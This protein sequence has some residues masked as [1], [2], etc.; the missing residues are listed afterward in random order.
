MEAQ[1]ILQFLTT[2]FPNKLPFEKISEFDL[3]VLVGQQQVI[4]DLKV[5]LKYEDDKEQEIK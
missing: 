5:K 4:E 3:G 2:K 1:Q